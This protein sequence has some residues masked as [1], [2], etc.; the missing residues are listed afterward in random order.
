MGKRV[1][2]VVDAMRKVIGENRHF[3]TVRELQDWVK[4]ELPDANMR[5]VEVVVTREFV[6]RGEAVK[7]S[8][9]TQ[10]FSKQNRWLGIYVMK[11]QQMK[12]ALGNL[13]LEKYY[14][15]LRRITDEERDRKRVIKKRAN[16]TPPQEDVEMSDVE[17][18]RKIIAYISELKTTIRSKDDEM[19]RV[20]RVSKETVKDLKG[21]IRQL[22]KK[23]ETQNGEI[24]I[25]RSR[26]KVRKKDP[27]KVFKLKDIAHIK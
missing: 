15:T 26:F 27:D 5:T 3:F 25:M 20:M 14:K 18:G 16:D 21:T 24:E 17:F 2:G 13:T 6:K 11:E 4:K 8:F 10:D 9:Q 12:N 7:S 23:I 1:Y 19:T 22:N